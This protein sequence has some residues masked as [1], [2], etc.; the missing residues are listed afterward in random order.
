MGSGGRLGLPWQPPDDGAIELWERRAQG[1]AAATHQDRD[2]SLSIILIRLNTDSLLPPSCRAVNLSLSLSSLLLRSLLSGFYFSLGNK[3]VIT[4]INFHF[5]Y[6]KLK[7]APIIF[8]SSLFLLPLFLSFAPYLSELFFSPH[9][10]KSKK[11]NVRTKQNIKRSPNIVQPP[12][13]LITSA[14]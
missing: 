3:S 10:Y 1:G 9:H 7:Y 8:S 12:Y 11:L 13:S 5:L 4:A 2:L 6:F 14:N